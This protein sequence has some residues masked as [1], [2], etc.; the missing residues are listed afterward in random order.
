[1]QD[2]L[3]EAEGSAAKGAR[4]FRNAGF[5]SLIDVQGVSGLLAPLVDLLRD[6]SA[7]HAIESRKRT[8]VGT[9][10]QGLEGE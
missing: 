1:L 5:R 4:G 6:T 9:L 10:T 8:W 7:R 3:I 2:V